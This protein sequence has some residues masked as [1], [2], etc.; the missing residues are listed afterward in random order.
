MKAAPSRLGAVDAYLTSAAPFAQPILHFL[1]ETIHEAAPEVTEAIKWSMPFFVYRGIIL[2]NMSAFKAHCSFSLWGEETIEALRAEGG[3][4]GGAMGSFGRITSVED[5]PSRQKLF[6]YIRKGAALIDGGERTR[7]LPVR[8]R[9]AKA[10]AVVPE[11]LAAALK[12]NPGADQ[13]FRSFSPSGRREYC[14]WIEEAKRPETRA[15]RV[16]TAMEW[17]AEGKSRNW[18]YE[19][20]R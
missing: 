8:Q 11:V 14:A 15:S 12:A 20:G 10:E 16:A 1:R 6:S 3:M 9:V 5:L 19:A 7:S 4:T 18:K 17:I 2:A 13:R